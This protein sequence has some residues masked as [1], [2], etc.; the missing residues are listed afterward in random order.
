MWTTLSWRHSVIADCGNTTFIL[1]P[2]LLLAG[3]DTAGLLQLC[4]S[5]PT[6][7]AL[8]H[9]Q[10]GVLTITAP[11]VVVS[12]NATGPENGR[13]VVLA[14]VTTKSHSHVAAHSLCTDRRSSLLSSSA[15][16]AA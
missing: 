6:G 3:I 5:L 13:F 15:L 14:I 12:S 11:N 2:T 8:V 10:P 9:V 4:G 7:G 1:I 16:A